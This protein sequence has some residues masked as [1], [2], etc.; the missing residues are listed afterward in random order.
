M[1]KRVAIARALAINPK[2]LLFDE[3]TSELDPPM[4][5]VING[6][7]LDLK[8]RLKITSIVVTHDMNHA[9]GIGDIIGMLY[10]GKI[11]EVGTPEEI[12]NT[13]TAVVQKF[14]ARDE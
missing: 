9:Y 8:E 5:K 14:I 13:T 10:N 6:L 12:M 11:I 4:A 2:I 1:K 7:M 3:P